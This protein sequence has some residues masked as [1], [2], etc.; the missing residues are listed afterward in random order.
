LVALLSHYCQTMAALTGRPE[1]D[2]RAEVLAERD[3][4]RAERP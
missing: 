3:R 2:I 1:A 4:L